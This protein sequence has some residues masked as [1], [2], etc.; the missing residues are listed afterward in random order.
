[1][2]ADPKESGSILKNYLNCQVLETLI[3]TIELEVVAL[4]LKGASQADQ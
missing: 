4:S 3:L 1:M 2:R